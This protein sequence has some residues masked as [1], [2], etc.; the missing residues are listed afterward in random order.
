MGRF[1]FKHDGRVYLI[2][3]DIWESVYYSR[4]GRKYKRAKRVGSD[5]WE[6]AHEE[7]ITDDH[8]WMIAA[9]IE[10]KPRHATF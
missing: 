9:C 5:R 4:D 3:D 7:A 10:R 6:N 2:A 8:F 1:T